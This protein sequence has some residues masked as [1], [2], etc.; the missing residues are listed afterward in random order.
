V[1]RPESDSI[2]WDEF[3]SF[4]CV[5]ATAG[6]ARRLHPRGEEGIVLVESDSKW[7]W[8][9]PNGDV[10][11]EAWEHH[12]WTEDIESLD[13]VWLGEAADGALRIVSGGVILASFNAG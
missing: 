4:V 2:L 3:D 13:V 5:A 6:E 7:H 11:D 1:S 12:S 9:F 10:D 8:V